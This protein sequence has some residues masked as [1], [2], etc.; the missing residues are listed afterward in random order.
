MQNFKDI[1]L[2]MKTEWLKNK[3]LH[4]WETFYIF[5]LS[6]C[7]LTCLLKFSGFFPFILSLILCFIIQ[8]TYVKYFIKQNIN[9][10]KTVE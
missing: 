9:I 3:I 10:D 4:T 2:K 8:Y 5:I 6:Y 1:L 7:I